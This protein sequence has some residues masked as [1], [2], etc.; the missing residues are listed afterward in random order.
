MASV[1]LRGVRVALLVLL[2]S[3][4]SMV[5][6]SE[7]APRQASPQVQAKSGLMLLMD[8]WLEQFLAD[9]SRVFHLPADAASEGS[10]PTASAPAPAAPM[11]FIGSQSGAAP[12]LKKKEK[13]KP[14]DG[15]QKMMKMDEEKEAPAPGDIPGLIGPGTGPKEGVAPNP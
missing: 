10:E 2:L 9:L 15:M 14:G 11:A 8:A 5:Q 6:A 7:Q 12:S 3:A 4:P 13:A 1:A